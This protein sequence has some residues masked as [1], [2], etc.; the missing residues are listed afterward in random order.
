M[1]TLSR[2]C[3]NAFFAN[4]QSECQISMNVEENT[5]KYTLVLFAVIS[6]AFLS[7]SRKASL[8]VCFAEICWTLPRQARH[9]SPSHLLLEVGWGT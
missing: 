7:H 6:N 4:S 2:Y 3:Q 5:E 9:G 1:T 8:L